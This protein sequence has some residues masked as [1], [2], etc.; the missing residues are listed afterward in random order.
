MV[1]VEQQVY[2]WKMNRKDNFTRDEWF[3]VKEV[4]TQ[5][6]SI[7]GYYIFRTK[8]TLINF[9]PM[10]YIIKLFCLHSN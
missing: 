3:L 1:V 8:K 6:F 9:T 7:I 5:Y 4:R 10:A 2:G